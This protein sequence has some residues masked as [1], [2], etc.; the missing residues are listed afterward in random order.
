MKIADFVVFLS[1][2]REKFSIVTYHLLAFLKKLLLKKIKNKYIQAVQEA[3]GFNKA[4]RMSES[5]SRQ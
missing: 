5:N 4:I 3:T 1:C 2:N